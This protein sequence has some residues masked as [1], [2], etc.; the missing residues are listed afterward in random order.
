MNVKGHLARIHKEINTMDVHG[1]LD[2]FE[3]SVCI[4][5]IEKYFLFEA[6]RKVDDGR[7][8]N[9]DCDIQERD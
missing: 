9:R 1:H 2:D 3:L 5:A 8:H 6:Q 4:N 7:Q